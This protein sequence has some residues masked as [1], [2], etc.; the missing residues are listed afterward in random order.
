MTRSAQL[1]MRWAYWIDLYDL[2]RYNGDVPVSNLHMC[3]ASWSPA[4]EDVWKFD[5]KVT[6]RASV[7]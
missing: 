4:E 1:H 6:S 5:S 7:T 2:R 3:K